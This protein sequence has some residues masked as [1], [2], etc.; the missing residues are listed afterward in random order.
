M[1]NAKHQVLL[2]EDSVEEVFLIRSFLEK[3]GIFEITLAQDGHTAAR[4]IGERDW[5]LIVTDLNLPGVDGYDLI[6]LA[7]SRKATTPVLATTGYTATHYVEQ[8]YRAGAD[9]VLVKPINRDEF[10]KKATELAMTASKQAEVK[11]AF[12]LAI[13]ALPGD[14]EAGCGGTLIGA[15]EKGQGV[16]VI[17]LTTT[18]DDASKEAQR[19]SAELMGARIIMPGGAVSSTGTPAE[20]QMLLERIVRELKPV[21]A[22]IP[23]L[24]EDNPHRREAHRLSRAAVA[25][26]PNLLAYESGSSSA[27]FAPNRFLDV[28]GAMIRKLE[29]LAAYA[30]LSRPDLDP[31]Y[32]QAAARHWGRHVKFGEAE[33][34]EVL[35]DQGKDA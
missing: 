4:R 21:T 6:R 22:F 2:V 16:L 11:V 25:Q 27:Q 3:T 10:V 28:E 12:V 17:P 7:K 18:T 30:G 14:V 1:S 13:G 19:K 5:D 35:R 9:H 15:K 8:A 31:G 23:S 26:V 29:A 24:A 33:A 34:F 20:H 32:I